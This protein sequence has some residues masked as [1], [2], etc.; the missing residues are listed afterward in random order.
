MIISFDDLAKFREAHKDQTIV[1]GSGVFDLIHRGH[2]AY[3]Q[4]LREYG[5]IV[6]VLVKS[7][8]RVRA[9]KGPSRPMLPEDDRVAMV[10]AI[11]GV[12][13]AF[14][15]P[16]VDF[17][18]TDFDPMYKAVLDALKPDV[19][20]STNPVWQKLA[21][22][23]NTKVIITERPNKTPLRSTTDIIAHVKSR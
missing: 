12:D 14:V 21:G 4:G 23:G 11:K 2:V 17:A 5:D 10:D 18:G 16:H 6:V 8:A 20:Q 3:L 7:D 15:A 1:L 22:Y 19:F 13:A 9:G